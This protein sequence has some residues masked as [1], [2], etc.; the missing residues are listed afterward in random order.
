MIRF[1]RVT[2]RFGTGLTEVRVLDRFSLDVPPGQFCTIMGPSGAGKSTTL[3]LLAG[4]TAPTA[5]EVSL[6]ERRLSAMS[7]RELA[8]VRRRE[9]GFVFQFFHLLPYLDAGENVALPLLMDGFSAVAVRERVDRTLALVDL[10]HRRRHKPA[11][12]SGGEM[13]RVAIARALVIEPRV[14]LADEPTGNLD[15]SASHGIMQ[16]LRRSNEQLG[17]TILMVTHD[18]VCA[19]YGDRVIRLVDGRTV[20]DI[21]VREHCPL[22]SLA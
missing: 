20:E 18:P 10:T 16:L 6:G 17:V 22:K 4:L 13:Q 11:Q 15:S 8:V 3:H 2:K 21:D 7:E 19:S 9:V 5:G 12:L 1:D 14:L